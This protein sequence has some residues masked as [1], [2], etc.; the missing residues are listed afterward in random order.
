MENSMEIPQKTKNRTIIHSSNSTPVYISKENENSNLKR[1]MH[2]NS[3]IIYNSQNTEATLV[4]INR[5]MD[6]EDVVY[7]YN[8][9]L[10]IH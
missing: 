5:W 2:P 1:Y 3:S 7:I 6:K 8:G 9:I 10:L 4:F